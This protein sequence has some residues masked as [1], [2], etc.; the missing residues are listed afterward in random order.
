MDPPKKIEKFEMKP[1][2]AFKRVWQYE[3]KDLS[4]RLIDR[5]TLSNVLG[6]LRRSGPS[7]PALT[8]YEDGVRSLHWNYMQ[9]VD[10]VMLMAGWL[11]SHCDV[12]GG[13][14]VVVISSNC[15][16]ALVTH[17][18]TMSIGAI[19]VPVNNSESE[20]VLK[21][22]VDQVAPRVML[23]GRRVDRTVRM[24]QGCRTVDL[25]SLPLAEAAALSNWPC[26][27]ILPDDPAVILF[28]SGTT[29]APKGVCLSHYNLMVNAEGL[30][31]I[32][33]LSVHR[34]HM[35][36]LPLFHANA[37][38]Y[39]MMASLYSGNH[40][41]LCDGFPGETIWSIIRDERIDILSAVPEILRV[42][43][44]IA[45]PRRNIPS[46]KYVVSAAAPLPREVALEFTSKTG[47][48]IHQGY[49]LSECVNFAATV[50]WDVSAE[51]LKMLTQNWGT[52]SIGPTLFGCEIGIRRSDGSA[53]EE[54][55]EGE[56]VVSGH[57][58]M[59]GYWGAEEATQAALTGGH[60]STGDLGFFATV[61]ARRYFFVTGRKKEI[62][63]RYGE[64]ISPFSIE[65]ELA[66]LRGVGPFAVV[67]FSN[68]AAG[69]EIGLYVK[70]EY[71]SANQKRVL[72]TVRQCSARYRPR[73]I[74]FGQLPVPATPT[75]K[76]KRSMLAQR[77]RPYARRSFGSDPVLFALSAD[78]AS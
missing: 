55:E 31:R 66:S 70:A 56:I 42:L 22:I 52:P 47:I 14:R 3:D 71:S 46:L 54:R 45:L 68:E 17:L 50:P 43:T 16:E 8:W 21:I 20:R 23:I 18:A 32:H 27:G 62:I 24:V 12:R 41:V 60:L 5:T 57:T 33:N 7:A 13:D 29:S 1:D 63:I 19:T 53:A 25:P 65:A 9:L 76:I 10:Q 61:D 35:C 69:E 48:D 40:V 15:P 11:R 44:E 73:V 38:G 59:L 26:P 34:K 77:F 72:D 78:V 4:S 39:S 49:G 75:G 2:L 67:G 64:N 6:G 37:F 74:V 30:A 36:I 51:T 58:V 28:T